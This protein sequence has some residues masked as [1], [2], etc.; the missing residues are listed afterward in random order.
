ML[1]STYK[2]N[3]I[4]PLLQG[5]FDRLESTFRRLN[6]YVLTKVYSFNRRAPSSRRTT[7]GGVCLRIHC[8]TVSS[9]IYTPSRSKCTPCECA[10]QARNGG[11]GSYDP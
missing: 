6:D 3:G 4:L 11:A 8:G 1:T 9:R 10:M 2:L 5:Y 7:P